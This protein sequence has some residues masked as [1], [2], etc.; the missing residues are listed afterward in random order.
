MEPTIRDENLDLIFV[1][2]RSGSMMGSEE[3]TLGGFN[4]FIERQKA[5]GLKTHVTTIL[6]DDHYEILYKR[7][8]INDVKPLT[9]DEYWVRGCTALLDAI[10]KTINTLDREIENKVLFVIMTD[11]LEN[12]SREFSK[13]QIRNLINNHDWEFIYIG[14]DIDSYSEAN[15][16]GIRKSRVAN[17]KKSKEGF[18]EVFTSVEHADMHLRANY[19]LDDSDWNKEL[20]K[21]D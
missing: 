4:S 9:E 18:K 1:M 17:Y 19:N 15:R 7:K 14:A 6:F 16:I 12:A 11:G 3:D 20:K 5:K 13:D 21:Y 2:D 8:D 10:G